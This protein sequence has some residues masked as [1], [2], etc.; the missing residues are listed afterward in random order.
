M[1]GQVVCQNVT[2]VSTLVTAN[3][4]SGNFELTY[5]GGLEP[6]AYTVSGW[7]ETQ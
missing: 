6:L 7:R 2:S 1:V 5:D 4:V 3:N